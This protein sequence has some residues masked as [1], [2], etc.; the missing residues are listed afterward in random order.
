[1]IYGEYFYHGVL[2][3]ATAKHA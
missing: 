3:T 2:N 1:L